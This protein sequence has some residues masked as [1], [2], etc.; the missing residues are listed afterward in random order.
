[1]LCWGGRVKET[2]IT[3]AMQP[4][5]FRRSDKVQVSGFVNGNN[6]LFV[7]RRAQ[8]MSY[9]MQPADWWDYVTHY[10]SKFWNAVQWKFWGVVNDLEDLWNSLLER[11]KRVRSK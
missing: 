5:M 3:V 11:L 2:S 6:G 9:L 7:V 1:M 8:G 10:A 4:D